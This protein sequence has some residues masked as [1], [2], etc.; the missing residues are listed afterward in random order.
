MSVAGDL[1][2]HRPS[3]LRVDPLPH[4]AKASDTNPIQQI[5]VTETVRNRIGILVGF[6][7]N[8]EVAA[9]RRTRQSG[10]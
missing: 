1:Y 8:P 3:G 4:H 7:D 9:T 6:I 5:E 2:R 10:Q